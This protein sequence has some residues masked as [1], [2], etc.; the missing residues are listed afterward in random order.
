MPNIRDEPISKRFYSARPQ[1]LHSFSHLF[2]FWNEDDES[3]PSPCQQHPVC[4]DSQV[5]GILNF[6]R[7]RVPFCE[8]VAP[9][10]LLEDQIIPPS[11]DREVKF[12]PLSV[13]LG[14]SQIELTTRTAIV[15]RIV[16]PFSIIGGLRP[17]QARNAVLSRDLSRDDFINPYRD[18]G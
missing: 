13:K 12:Q 16:E 1:M 4:V 18:S 2:R 5:H 15:Q 14:E 7:V 17:F 11:K 6:G 8:L 10:P 9:L 3:I